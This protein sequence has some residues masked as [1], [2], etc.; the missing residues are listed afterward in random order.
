MD[1]VIYQYYTLALNGYQALNRGFSFTRFFCPPPC[2]YLFGEG[3]RNRQQLLQQAGE[4]D[5]KSQPVAFIGIGNNNEQ[6][7]QQLLIEEKVRYMDKLH[8]WI[9]M[10]Y[11]FNKSTVSI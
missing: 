5:G 3:W 10:C 8:V 1:S 9:I 6:D 4:D 2:V 7:M 11:V